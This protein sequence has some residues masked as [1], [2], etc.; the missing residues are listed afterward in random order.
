MSHAE[1]DN[2]VDPHLEDTEDPRGGPTWVITIAGTILTVVTCLAVGGLYFG[3]ERREENRKFVADASEARE[4]QRIADKDRLMEEAHWETYTDG[5]GDMVI[6]RKLKLPIDQAKQIIVD[7][8]A[9]DQN[10]EEAP[11]KP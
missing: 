3:A 2:Q 11:S 8:Y 6:E 4:T 9:S 7:R 10:A 5:S 1:H